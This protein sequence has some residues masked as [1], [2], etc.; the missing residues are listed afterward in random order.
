MVK[1]YKLIETGRHM[2]A[3]SKKVWNKVMGY[4][5]GRMEKYTKVVLKLDLWMDLVLCQWK[6][7]KVISKDFS[8]EIW[9]TETSKSKHSSDS[10]KVL[11]LMVKWKAR[12][13]LHGLMVKY[14]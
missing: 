5:A 4:I 3:N 9:S 14:M 10:M 8:T 7:G 11:S 1:A 6:M 12:E 13:N 2:K